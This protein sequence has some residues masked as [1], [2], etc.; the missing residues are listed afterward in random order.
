MF[1]A[2]HPELTTAVVTFAA[3]P[4]TLRDDDYPW[5]ATPEERAYL[6]DAVGTGALDLDQLLRDLAPTDATDASTRRLVDDLLALGRQCP[7]SLD[8]ILAMGPVDVRGVLGAVRAPALVLHR[9]GD[10]MADIRA[11]RYMAERLG[12]GPSGAAGRRPLP[13]LRRPGRGG[14][15]TQEF[16]TGSMPVPD[17]TGWSLTV[18]FTDIVGSTAR[19]SRAG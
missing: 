9:S 1:A 4:A 6:I 5:G 19:A 8:E 17:P 3:H 13:L 16:L 18:L 12:G 7:E 15:R 10:R 11:S 2:T 14:R